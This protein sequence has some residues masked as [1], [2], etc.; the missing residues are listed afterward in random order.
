MMGGV[1]DVACVDWP[2]ERLDLGEGRTGPGG[3]RGRPGD[4]RESSLVPHCLL[5][6]QFM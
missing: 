6:V 3:G 5:P 2:G 1:P 4:G